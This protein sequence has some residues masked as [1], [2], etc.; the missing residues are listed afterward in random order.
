MKSSCLA[1]LWT[2]DPMPFDSAR[3]VAFRVEYDGTGYSGWQSQPNVPK[4]IQN[5]LEIAISDFVGCT[6]VV[7]GASRTDAGVHARDQLAAVTIN[8][9]ASLDGFIKAVNVR[10]PDAISIRAP[11]EVTADFNPRFEN[12]GKTYIYRVYQSHQR[13]PLQARWAWR[14]PWP[15]DAERIVA[16]S[17]NLIGSHDF[18]SFAATDGSH[19]SAI[20]TLTQL[21]FEPS[22]DGCFQFILTGTAF[23]KNMVRIIVGTLV[24]A[25]RGRLSADDIVDILQAKDRQAAGPTAP[26]HGLCLAR[27]YAHFEDVELPDRLTD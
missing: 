6:S 13:R 16:A 20:R 4:T 15:L 25:G 26:A 23:M 19:K 7:Q 21:E 5:Q 12:H 2:S 1:W 8:H 18:T 17:N 27:I 9:P 22:T 14:L 3:R 24:E 10:L 11:R